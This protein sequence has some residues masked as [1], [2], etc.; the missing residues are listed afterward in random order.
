LGK[1]MMEQKMME[2]PL[3]GKL[4]WAEYLADRKWYRATVESVDIHGSYVVVFTDYGNRQ[5]CYPHQ[6]TQEFESIPSGSRS[7][8]S[9]PK[10]LP[11]KSDLPVAPPRS[12]RGENL[13]FFCLIC[14][15]RVFIVGQFQNSGVD[16][17]RSSP[18]IPSLRPSP[19]PPPQRTSAPRQMV[20]QSPPAPQKVRSA[21]GGTSTGS[22]PPP[23]PP[24]RSPTPIVPR[25]A[26]PAR[27]AMSPNDPR[28]FFFFFNVFFVFFLFSSS[29]K[30]FPR[31]F[32][33]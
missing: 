4:V 24:V 22:H 9:S 33:W 14:N 20:A 32:H 28:R 5:M 26:A 11:R 2:D 23:R 8:P 21:T 18:N 12:P 3:V 7:T 31:V 17:R 1:V 15:F 19:S 29:K 10:L 13:L 6:I 30:G 25:P 27:G 16:M